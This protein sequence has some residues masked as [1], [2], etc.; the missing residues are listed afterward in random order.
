[1]DVDAGRVGGRVDEDGD[2]GARGG[3]VGEP[4]AGALADGAVEVVPHEEA[5]RR[6]GG[7]GLPPRPHEDG[8]VVEGEGEAEGDGEG[9][10]AVVGVE[11]L[12]LRPVRPPDGADGAAEGDDEPA[13]VRVPVDD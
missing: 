6:D 5:P 2:G 3:G 11:D 1:P 13:R 10:E 9:G 4:D 8:E 12:G 7:E